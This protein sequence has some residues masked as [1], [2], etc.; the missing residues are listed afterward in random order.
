[1]IRLVASDMDGTLLNRYGKVSLWNTNAI[2]ALEQ[3]NVGFVVCTGRN[4]EDAYTPLAEAGIHCDIICMNGAAAFNKKGERLRNQP[5]FQSQVTRILDICRPF[6][7][8]FDFMTEAG[9]C[10]ITS[11][12]ELKK[13]FENKVFLSM[14]ADELSYEIIESRFQ[15]LTEES[16][17]N[18]GTDIF[19]ISVVHENPVV[20][21]QIRHHLKME[22]GISIASS[23]STNLEL[24]H[25]MAQ[26]GSALMEYAIKS[27]IHPREILALGDSENDLSMLGLPIGYTIAM[28]N[29]SDAVKRNARIITRT[30]DEDGVALAIESLILSKEA[31]VS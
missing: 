25:A 31:A 18:T 8:L 6:S 7:V 12:E 13:S 1:M 24:T 16:L 19:K 11:R 29:A 9:S 30:N 3:K 17:L 28:G 4:Y 22:E 20:L 26:K 10:T 5:L 23:A 15:F 2:K 27:K 14:C 21:E